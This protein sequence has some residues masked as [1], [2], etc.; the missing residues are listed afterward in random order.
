KL[1]HL[2]T[3]DLEK[4]KK[5]VAALFV[6]FS[7]KSEKYPGIKK[8]NEIVIYLLIGIYYMM[9]IQ[10][11]SSKLV[12]INQHLLEELNNLPDMDIKE[13]HQQLLPLIR[14]R[15]VSRFINEA[16]MEKLAKE[17]KKESQAEFQQRLIRGYQAIIKNKKLKADLAVW[18]ETL[19]DSDKKR[20]I[21]LENK[22]KVKKKARTDTS[23]EKREYLISCFELIE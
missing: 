19:G 22:K 13:L 20:R 6:G 23:L 5:I 7:T 14:E 17:H 2:N 21:I 1:P 11:C 9:R 4:A 10:T 12:H 18:N 15:K 3:D 8:V 16:V